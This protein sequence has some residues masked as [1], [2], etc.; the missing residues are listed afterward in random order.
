MM[1]VGPKATLYMP[2]D[3]LTPEFHNPP[4]FT[5]YDVMP[6]VAGLFTAIFID[7][8]RCCCHTEMSEVERPEV[9]RPE[10]ERSEVRG[11]RWPQQRLCEQPESF[12]L[13]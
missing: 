4:L 8:I 1:N 6:V 7:S 9:K 10:V 5:N 13:L 2:K 3:D 12:A 11:Q